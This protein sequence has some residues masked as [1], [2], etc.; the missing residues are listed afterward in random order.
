MK[1]RDEFFDRENRYSLGVDV[2][3]GRHYASIPV[4]NGAVD[5]EEYYEL[6]ADEY[7]RLLT[8]SVAAVV[9]VDECRRHERDDLLLVQPGTNRGTAV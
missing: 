3:S 6:S 8:D 5:Y 4:S 1:L 9:F 7:V 2:D